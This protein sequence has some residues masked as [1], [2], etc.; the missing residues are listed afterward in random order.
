V[1]GARSGDRI[2]I[3]TKPGS[4]HLASYIVVIENPASTKWTSPVT[5]L[6]RSESR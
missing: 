6:E 1:S 3:S 4:C 5:P 2:L